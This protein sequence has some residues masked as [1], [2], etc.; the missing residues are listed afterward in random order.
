MAALYFQTLP[1]LTPTV[2][3]LVTVVFVLVRLLPGD[4]FSSEKLTP[5]IRANLEH[6]TFRH[7]STCNI[8]GISAIFFGEISAFP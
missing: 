3:L 2:W 1:H 7:L 6:T 5:A 8:S 4:P